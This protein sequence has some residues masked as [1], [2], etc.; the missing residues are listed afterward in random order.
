MGHFRASKWAIS[1]YR[2]Q[3]FV[4]ARFHARFSGFA[5]EHPNVALASWQQFTRIRLD[6]GSVVKIFTQLFDEIRRQQQEPVPG[7]W[8]SVSFK[9]GQREIAV[10]EAFWQDR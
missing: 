9:V 4:L 1:D 2:N 7:F 10:E 8:N 3:L 5:V 6:C